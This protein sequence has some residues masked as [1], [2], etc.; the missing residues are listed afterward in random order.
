MTLLPRVLL[1]WQPAQL[2]CAWHPFVVDHWLTGESRAVPA[3]GYRRTGAPW[4]QRN[5]PD[6][7]GLAATDVMSPDFVDGAMHVSAIEK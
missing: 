2:G 3:G 1:S 4:L 5:W 6:L 7:T